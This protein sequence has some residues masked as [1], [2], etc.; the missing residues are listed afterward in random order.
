MVE[1]TAPASKRFAVRT[2]SLRDAAG[3]LPIDCVARV[4]GSL[5]YAPCGTAHDGEFVGTYTITPL[6]V[7]YDAEKVPAAA[8]TGCGNLTNSF[9]GAART[10]LRSGYVGP[11]SGS[12]WLGSDQTY[13]CYALVT[14]ADK[15]RGSVKGIGSG[16]LPR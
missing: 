14:G 1:A 16:P 2:A 12:D 5:A 7:P 15:I 10:D 3:A 4:D 11:A 6:D 8:T 9:V 13:A